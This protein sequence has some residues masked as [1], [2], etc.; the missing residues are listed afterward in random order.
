MPRLGDFFFDSAFRVRFEAKGRFSA[1]LAAVPTA[2][3]TDT[4]VALQGAAAALEGTA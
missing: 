4:L 2:V 3:I 1:Y